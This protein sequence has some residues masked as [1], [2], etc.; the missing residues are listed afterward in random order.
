MVLIMILF[1]QFVFYK[2][3]RLFTREGFNNFNFNLN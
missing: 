1:I 2:G 3:S